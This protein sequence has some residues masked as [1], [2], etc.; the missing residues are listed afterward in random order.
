M[1]K[2]RT[3]TRRTALAPFT[4]TLEFKNV[5][6]ILCASGLINNARHNGRKAGW[7]DQVTGILQ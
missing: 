6:M 5:D 4:A 3:L 7:W 2:L 1:Y